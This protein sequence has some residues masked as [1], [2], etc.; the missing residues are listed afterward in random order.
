MRINSATPQEEVPVS[1]APD[2]IPPDQLPVEPK[3]APSPLEP[4][5]APTFTPGPEPVAPEPEAPVVGPGPDRLPENPSPPPP[6]APSDSDLPA[7]VGDEI[8]DEEPAPISEGTAPPLDG[9]PGVAAPLPGG[10]FGVDQ[11]LDVPGTQPEAPVIGPDIE[12]GGE[13]VQEPSVEVPIKHEPAQPEPPEEPIDP[14]KH[15]PVALEEKIGG[16]KALPTQQ[17]VAYNRADS[18][19]VSGI[20]AESGVQGQDVAKEPVT[21]RLINETSDL[22]LERSNLLEQDTGLREGLKKIRRYGENIK[23]DVE[24]ID[25]I[26]EQLTVEYL[27]KAGEIPPQTPEEAAAMGE[28]N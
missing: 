4:V 20:Q 8:A 14:R 9:V 28:T 6:P 27:D 1:S 2:A 5:P 16:S 7:G 25:R 17:E 3:P 22:S 13:G 15:D 10:E 23:R 19:N 12:V 24:E 26:R 18:I 11:T 21:D